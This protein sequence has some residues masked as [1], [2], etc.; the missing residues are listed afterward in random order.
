[1]PEMTEAARQDG[2]SGNF[3]DAFEKRN[4]PEGSKPTPA[5][6][7]PSSSQ[8]K[9]PPRKFKSY[10][11]NPLD[12]MPDLTTRY[13]T[14][15][16]A[17]RAASSLFKQWDQDTEPDEIQHLYMDTSSELHDHWE[18][19]RWSMQWL[20]NPQNREGPTAPDESHLKILYHLRS[21]IQE[22]E[23]H[24][25][26]LLHPETGRR[27]LFVDYF[28]TSLAQ[29]RKMQAAIKHAISDAVEKRNRPAES[30]PPW[31]ALPDGPVPESDFQLP[32][33]QARP[34]RRTR[35][36][37]SL[38]GRPD[39]H[40]L[41]NLTV[42]QRNQNI[43]RDLRA[44]NSLFLPWSEHTEESEFGPLYQDFD[45]VLNDA[46]ENIRD[47][48]MFFTKVQDS[49]DDELCPDSYPLD[50][51]LDIQT[52]VDKLVNHLTILTDDES[53]MYDEFEELLRMTLPEARR[54]QL[55]VDRAV[56]EATFNQMGTISGL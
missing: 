53:C 47:A 19:I 54:I 45:S 7:K 36:Y 56:D 2:Q 40:F 14:I 30:D 6:P 38:P 44:A 10:R 23:W 5:A 11:A 15:L 49:P 24:V 3:L 50:D 39:P 17:L 20:V 13:Q 8:A 51:P 33:E 41:P 46:W 34:Y 27:D 4:R 55:I 29:V 35:Q 22:M 1:V 43:L 21:V 25:N 28:E 42:A 31:P 9:A 12:T 16:D 26:E 37:S 48:E 32:P 52:E 18:N